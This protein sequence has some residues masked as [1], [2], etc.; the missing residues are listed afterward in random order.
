M[1]EPKTKR[2]K[3]PL[4]RLTAF[5]IKHT[6][7][8]PLLLPS[9]VRDYRNVLSFV[10]PN[11]VEDA[12]ITL[13]GNVINTEVRFG[14]G[15]ARLVVRLKTPNGE[16][17]N[18]TQ[19]GYAKDLESSAKELGNSTLCVHGRVSLFNND[20][21]LKNIELVSEQW[22]G[23]LCPVYPLKAGRIGSEA[24]RERL[25][26]LLMPNL[27][28][29]AEY[30]VNEAAGG[31]VPDY[32]RLETICKML[33][34]CYPAEGFA[35]DPSSIKTCQSACYKALG[36]RIFAA[37]RPV[38]LDQFYAAIREIEG[39]A[40]LTVYLDAK[41]SASLGAKP[42]WVA[43]RDKLM[44]AIHK[45]SEVIPFDLIEEQWDV[46]NDLAADLCNKEKP[47]CRMISGD[48]GTGKTIVYALV[49][50][51]VLDLGGR[52]ACLMPGVVLAQQIYSDLIGWWP[53]L[54]EKADLVI[55]STEADKQ[56]KLFVG[57]TALLSRDLGFIDFVVVDEQ[58]RF[59][60]DQREKLLGQ[61]SHLA[62]VSG[63][64]IPRTQ[65]LIKFG[66]A[67]CSRL[68]KCHADKTIHTNLFAQSDRRRLFDGVKRTLANNG[69]VL[70]VYPARGDKASE[71]T[72]PTAHEG[73]AKWEQIFPGQ[74]VLATG[75]MHEDELE[76]A[77]DD[78]R[79]GRKRILIS[80]IVVEVGVNIPDLEHVV[81]VHAE[82]MGLVT[83]HQVRGRVVRHGGTG[84]CDLFLPAEVGEDSMNRLQV[85]IE[86]TDGY[87]V[88]ERD[89]E[90]RGFGDLRSKSSDQSGASVGAL[91]GKEI[92][93]AI[94]TS[95]IDW[96]ES[97]G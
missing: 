55:S 50:A 9:T 74:C 35:A 57:T 78:M 61:G 67:D 15:A 85:L 42:A 14:S 96:A 8:V 18:Y 10:P 23:K 27:N 1:T 33:Q 19:F 59:S 45:R 86:E 34:V 31:L 51:G 89:M 73:F 88:A 63:T 30:L 84:Y 20:L 80:T 87:R 37:H 6:Y 17:F 32:N 21:W 7:Q 56:N 95:V 75:G 81:V 5:G 68:T 77:L 22:V 97:G 65:A 46:V 12:E 79:S 2:R 64:F 66:I 41:S 16:F 11:L 38:S 4:G 39:F 91:Y 93:L 48:V 82:R 76:A 72:L 28:A 40:A 52:V 71:G 70:V 29:C 69:Q 54:A 43:D 94:M 36:E 49:V 58:Q 24:V 3:S 53:D 26:P 92:P 62:E 44:A 83:L 60:R 13:F 25:T 47:A 90:L